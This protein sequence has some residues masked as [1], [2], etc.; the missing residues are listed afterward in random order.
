MLLIWAGAML[1][2]IILLVPE[3]YHPVLLRQKA[4]KLRETSGDDRWKAPIEHMDRSLLRTVLRSIYRPFL[5][6]TLEPMCTNLCIFSALLLGVLYL[7]F[8]A[9]NLIFQANHGFE[10]WQTGLTFLGL[11][12]G[13]LIA[14]ASDPYWHKIWL[15]LCQNSGG[16]QPEYRLP[17]AIGGSVL[18]PIGLFWYVEAFL[19]SVAGSVDKSSAVRFGWTS[20]SSV[21]WYV[22]DRSERKAP[23]VVKVS[24]NSVRQ[25]RTDRGLRR[26]WLRVGHAS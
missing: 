9:F 16:P 1:G 22:E 7:F 4:I 17:P 10:L 11:F 6:L 14:I 13:I 24:S 3:T 25:D 26:L 15:R 19:T 21:H 5:L 2:A 8:G 23:E 12:V 18:V 20:Y